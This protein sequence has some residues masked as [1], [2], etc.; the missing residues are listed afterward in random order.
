MGL[1]L[2]RAFALVPE[3]GK[4]PTETWYHRGSGSSASLTQAALRAMRSLAMGRNPGDFWLWTQ[5]YHHK[6][7][8]IRSAQYLEVPVSTTALKWTLSAS[9]LTWGCALLS[10][11]HADFCLHAFGS[12]VSQLMVL[13]SPTIQ[14]LTASAFLHHLVYPALTHSEVL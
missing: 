9:A 5:V 1:G 6:P 3:H 12:C 13:P 10:T 2:L 11:H 8:A 14:S 7:S 4:S